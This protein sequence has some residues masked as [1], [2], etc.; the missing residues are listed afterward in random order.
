[1]GCVVIMQE[2]ALLYSRAL[3]DVFL[4]RFCIFC[5]RS[6]PSTC[7]ISACLECSKAA[8]MPDGHY[9]S[10][11]AAPVGEHARK[12]PN[13]HNLRIRLDG[14]AAFGLYE[15]VL[16]ERL[17]EFKF[18][19]ARYLA[20]TLGVLAGRA[21][22]RRWP[23]VRFDIVAGVPLH[24]S[25]RRERGFDQGMELARWAARELDVPYASRM[26]K[27]KRCTESQVGL[28]R[29]ARLINVRGAFEVRLPAGVR[30]VLLVD[31]T[32]TTGATASEAARSLKRAGVKRV[33]GVVAARANLA[34]HIER[35]NNGRGRQDGIDRKAGR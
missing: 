16:R 3:A 33:Y 12:C 15:G 26:L 2:A 9:C 5:G 8:A 21:A 11:C 22:R 31:D 17:L 29:S 10:R 35:D 4:P 18:Q 28:S 20:L 6:V 7:A 25:R 24:G 14:A 27:R 19:G 23:E 32:M 1:M 30:S 34:D 13:C